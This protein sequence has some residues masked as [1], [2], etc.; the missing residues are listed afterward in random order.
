[1]SSAEQSRHQEAAEGGESRA[2]VELGAGALEVVGFT[3]TL[4]GCEPRPVFHEF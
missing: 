4:M 1:M 3:V 2:L